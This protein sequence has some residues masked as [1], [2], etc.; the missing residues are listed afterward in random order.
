MFEKSMSHEKQGFIIDI[1][2]FVAS[3]AKCKN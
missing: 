3:I 2:E 1:D